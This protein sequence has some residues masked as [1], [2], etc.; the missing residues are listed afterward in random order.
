MFKVPVRKMKSLKDKF[1]LYISLSRIFYLRN[2]SINNILALAR[3]VGLG[4]GFTIC[5]ELISKGKENIAY[6]FLYM[7]VSFK[8]FIG[9]PTKS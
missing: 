7:S 9:L 8:D 1:N 4:N 2:R 3:L 6:Y 5:Y